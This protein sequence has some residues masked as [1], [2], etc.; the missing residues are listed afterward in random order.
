MRPIICVSMTEKFLS[1]LQFL[2]RITDFFISSFVVYSVLFWPSR[3]DSNLLWNPGCLK[4][5]IPPASDSWAV[6]LQVCAI[7]LS[8]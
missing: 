8:W 1:F 7:T 5:H 2:V 4:A 3:I 6:R